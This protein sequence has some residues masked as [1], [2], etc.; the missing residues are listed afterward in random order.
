MS[1]A[2]AQDVIDRLGTELAAELTNEGQ[3][4]TT[5]DSIMIAEH[6]AGADAVIDGYLAQR[7]ATP[8]SVAAQP[9]IAALLKRLTLDVAIHSLHG[10]ALDIPEAIKS[11]YDAALALLKDF[12]A[13]KASLPVENAT[14]AEPAYQP[15]AVV[16]DGDERGFSREK[17]KGL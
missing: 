9:S 3:S 17:L 15:S 11:A 6:V 1:Y 14:V 8:V 10:R 4:S 12:Q 13:G 16:T 5:P 7:Y 2:S